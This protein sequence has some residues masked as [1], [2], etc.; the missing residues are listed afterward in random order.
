[1]QDHIFMGAATALVTPFD[2]E[3]QVNYLKLLELLEYQLHNG[4]VMQNDGRVFHFE[5]IRKVVDRSLCEGSNQRAC[6]ADRGSG[7]KLYR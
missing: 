4:A 7:N 5:Q 3:G 6:A 1:M 2:K